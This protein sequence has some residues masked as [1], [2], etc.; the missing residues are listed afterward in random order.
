LSSCDLKAVIETLRK[1]HPDGAISTA[2]NRAGI[3]TT[4]GKTWTRVQVERY[5]RRMGIVEFDLQEKGT[6]SWLTQSETATRLEISP[7][8]VHRLVRNGILPA[9]QPHPGLPMM[10][11]NT[12]LSLP[13]VERAVKSLKAGH[14]R[15]LPDD[16][17]QL[18]LF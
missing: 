13:E 9:D 14:T 10:I 16:P 15:P 18:K 5:R 11:H 2:L 3:R 8:S 4:G 1:V 6:S 17:S 12:D 7:M